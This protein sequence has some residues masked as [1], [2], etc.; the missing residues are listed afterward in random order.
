MFRRFKAYIKLAQ[1]KVLALNKLKLCRGKEILAY[2]GS[3]KK[4]TQKI[5]YPY[6]AK[7]HSPRRTIVRRIL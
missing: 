1:N 5:F 3:F 6:Y 4:W 7:G 2:F